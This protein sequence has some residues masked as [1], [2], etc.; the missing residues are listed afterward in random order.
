[1]W[2]PVGWSKLVCGLMLVGVRLDGRVGMCEL[3]MC[4]GVGSDTGWEQWHGRVVDRHT[5]T[6]RYSKETIMYIYILLYPSIFLYIHDWCG[7][8]SLLKGTDVLVSGFAWSCVVA[9]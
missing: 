1:M 5:S 9:C 7:G 8:A 2:L 3:I 6:M 4:I